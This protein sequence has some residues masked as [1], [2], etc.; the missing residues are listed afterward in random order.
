MKILLVQESDWLLRNPHQQHHLMDRLSAKGHDIRVIDFGI[1]WRRKDKKW[2]GVYV[3][4]KIYP[5]ISKVVDNA[6]ITVIRPGIIEIPLIDY[7][8]IPYF[9]SKEINQQ[10]KEFK[11]DVILA[12]G[13][14][15]A[16]F[17]A[18]AAEKH[19]IPFVYY[20][21]DVLYAL[22]PEKIFQSLGKSLKKKT[23]KKSTKVI[24]INKRLAELAV[25]LGADKDNT[26]IIDAGIDLKRFKPD[27]SGDSIRREYS[28]KKEDN[29]LFFMGWI[30]NFAGIK[31]I[32]E[33]L[34]KNKDKYPHTKLLI[35]GDGD[36][37]NDLVDIRE[38]Y[39]LHDQ[40]ILTGKKPYERIPEFIA[41]SNIC[42]LPAYQDEE[43]MQD[44]VPI[45]LYE[46]MAMEKPVIATRFPGISMEFGE[47]NGIIYV[48]GPED[49][50][51]LVDNLGSE[52]IVKL[53]R[54]ARKYVERNDWEDITRH[55]Q[56]TLEKLI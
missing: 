1:D 19:G 11:P 27:I 39:Q 25:E 12:F 36:A 53:G 14:L 9:H 37:Y 30:Y 31:E 55:F 38:K 54:K 29:V 47:G 22:I 46:Y 33:D 44:I 18:R 32:A 50:L 26:M 48:N 7:M 17:A 16:Y 23:L 51:K 45:K 56:Q 35:V 6:K 42:L 28:I 41:A 15:N 34:G 13:L 21:I 52:E 5:D 49:V 2:K 40:L 10:I 8:T 20:L 24:T 3:R 4:R 43:I